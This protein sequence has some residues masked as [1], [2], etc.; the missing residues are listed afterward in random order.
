VQNYITEMLP[1]AHR[2][3]VKV[4]TDYVAAIMDK[5]TGTQAALARSFGNQ[6]AACKR[7]SRLLLR[8]R[9]EQLLRRVASRR[10]HRCELSV[11]T[12]MVSLLHQEWQLLQS[13]LSHM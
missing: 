12:I 2:H 8:E 1:W 11:I 4:I 3:Q 6:E 9:N 7:I 10:H 13:V 5:Q